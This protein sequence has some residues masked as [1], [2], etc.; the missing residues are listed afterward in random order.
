MLEAQFVLQLV[1]PCWLHTDMENLKI[2]EKNDKILDRNVEF[3][4]L[5]LQ[6]IDFEKYCIN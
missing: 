4:S 1:K 5:R 3:I 2:E 6:S